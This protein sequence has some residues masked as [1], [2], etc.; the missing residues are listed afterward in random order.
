LGV[1]A[2]APPARL[3]PHSRTQGTLSVT[4]LAR[5][6]AYA[7]AAALALAL[8]ACG[9]DEPGEGPRTAVSEAQMEEGLDALGFARST[10]SPQPRP[11]WRTGSRFILA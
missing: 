10:C 4:K 2:Y 11:R 6:S 1:R 3:A 5:M 9:S 8:A 7:S